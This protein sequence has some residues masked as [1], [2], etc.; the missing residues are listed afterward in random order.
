ML[1][2]I[3][4]IVGC[5]GFLKPRGWL[6]SQL[7]DSPDLDLGGVHPLHGGG[8]IAYVLHVHAFI[9]DAHFVC[10]DFPLPSL[11]SRFP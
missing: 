10:P 9:V 3:L 11:S 4:T 8:D 5:L 1:S 6:V 2:L 7:E